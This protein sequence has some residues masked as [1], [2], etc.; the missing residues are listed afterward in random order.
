MLPLS[1]ES[2]EQLRE[3][4]RQEVTSCKTGK[5]PHRML[6][7]S[8]DRSVWAGESP[9]CSSDCT[10]PS[11]PAVR[12]SSSD[13]SSP[14]AGC[15]SQWTP[16]PP[17]ARPPHSCRWKSL[18]GKGRRRRLNISQILMTIWNKTTSTL[19]SWC[20]THRDLEINI[21]LSVW[22]SSYSL[23]CWAVLTP[24]LLQS[25]LTSFLLPTS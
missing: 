23:F 5:I 20:L 11:I 22:Q 7:F 6:R 1:T 13:W 2:W 16:R 24:S 8:F 17:P 4:S 18:C 12:P 10:G 21:P 14:P 25:P 15:R 3:V 9:S 19:L